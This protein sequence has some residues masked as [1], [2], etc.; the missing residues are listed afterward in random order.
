MDLFPGMIVR[1]SQ[2]GLGNVLYLEDMD[3]SE[4]YISVVD[5][6]DICMEDTKVLS[7]RDKGRLARE[8][9]ALHTW[10]TRKGMILVKI[11]DRVVSLNS[12]YFIGLFC[13]SV[14]LL[15]E[16][17][18]REKYVFECDSNI[19]K[20]TED[21]I[22]CCLRELGLRGEMFGSEWGYYSWENTGTI[23]R[24]KRIYQGSVGSVL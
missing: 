9:F 17:V 22:Y 18:F 19:R 20:N 6:E 11:P 1:H 3:S 7:G 5:L 12:S 2:V 24:Y 14:K 13:D 8:I 23:T 15:G 16:E 4:N 10:D 21:G